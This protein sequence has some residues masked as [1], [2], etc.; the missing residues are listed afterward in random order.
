MPRS[1]QQHAVIAVGTAMPIALALLLAAVALCSGCATLVKGSTQ[2][3]TVNTEPAG[4]ICTLARDGKTLA[5]INPTPGSIPVE[6]ASGPISVLCRRSGFEDA[7]GTLASEFQSMTFGNILFGGLIG[8]VVDAASGAANQYPD[9]VT[10]TMIPEGFATA[11]D[12]DRFFDAMKATLLSESAEV[13]ERIGKLCRPEACAAELAAAD[14][15]MQAKLA[16]I[17]QRRVSAP[18]RST[19]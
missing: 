13:K 12:R 9:A 8:I 15:G 7:A 4:A 1:G 14:A 10:I 16:E 6:K 17:E 19:K 11:E 3:I 5:I 2:T 18:V